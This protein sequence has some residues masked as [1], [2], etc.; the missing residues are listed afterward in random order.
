ML[1]RFD[2]NGAARLFQLAQSKGKLISMDV[3]CL[4]ILYNNGCFFYITFIA[5]LLY[6]MVLFFD[7]KKQLI[8]YNGIIYFVGKFYKAGLNHYG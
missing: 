8:Y 2:G 1:P 4:R 5:L 3:N 6:F 7:D